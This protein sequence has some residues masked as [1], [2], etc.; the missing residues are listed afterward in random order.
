[1]TRNPTNRILTVL[2]GLILASSLRAQ[3]EPTAFQERV[4]RDRKERGIPGLSVVV[5]G[6]GEVV[7]ALGSGL[8]DVEQ[9]VL[10]TPHTRFRTASL[11]KPMTAVALLALFEDGLID[12]DADLHGVVPDWPRKR[13]AVSARQLM[14]HLGG[15]RHYR[16]AEVLS[17]KRY[18]SLAS[19][20]RIFAGDPLIHEPGTAYRY[21]TYGYNLL[22]RLVEVRGE[23]AFEKV[24]QREVL[25][26][27]GMRE[28]VVDDVQAIIPR[29]T[30]YYLRDARGQ[31]RHDRFID[32]SYKVPGGGLLTTASDLGLF[33]RSLLDQRLL[34]TPTKE[35][36]WTEQR[37]RSGD[38]VG[39]GLGFRVRMREKTL[40]VSHTGGQQGTT[41]L[42]LLEPGRG[43]GIAIL[44]N[45]A[46]VPDI[47]GLGRTWLDL[48]VP[49]GG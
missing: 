14:A 18:R 33:L 6:G 44:T 46:R 38:G 29:R 19:G 32:P 4:D 16:G 8:A 40:E 27:A 25:G 10:A 17:A 13:W 22:G 11:S 31:L 34:R 20:L 28:T 5:I 43:R 9:E 7:H 21:T 2:V 12:L 35:L 41:A 42:L 24:L 37:T 39:Y 1:M 26:P 3:I 15:V 36:M 45:L 30:R 48:T 23:G 49:A 47:T